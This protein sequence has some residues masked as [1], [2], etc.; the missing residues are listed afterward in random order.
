MPK[1][2]MERGFFSCFAS[3]D[4][5]LKIY[6]RQREFSKYLNFVWPKLLLPCF[7]GWDQGAF[8]N[9]LPAQPFLPSNLSGAC[10]Q[11]LSPWCIPARQ[12]CSPKVHLGPLKTPVLLFLEIPA[13][14][15]HQAFFNYSKEFRASFLMQTFTTCM[16]MLLPSLCCMT[17]F[18]IGICGPCRENIN[19]RM[20]KEARPQMFTIQ[21]I[22]FFTAY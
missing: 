22:K 8:G 17:M 10:G 16:V 20:F 18:Y 11:R 15:S 12:H 3:S 1:A 2:F 21:S 5:A 9:A 7:P 19:A 6:R 4:F 14:Q 13:T